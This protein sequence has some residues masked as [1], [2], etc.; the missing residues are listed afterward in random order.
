[1]VMISAGTMKKVRKPLA[2]FSFISPSCSGGVG[3]R[4]RNIDVSMA[5][6]MGNE[7]YPWA[8]LMG[9]CI[10]II[11]LQNNVDLFITFNCLY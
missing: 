11:L 1:M 9:M 7:A 8:A 2:I 5:A 6:L 10:I 4:A 3:I